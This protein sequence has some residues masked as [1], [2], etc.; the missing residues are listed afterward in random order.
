MELD[1]YAPPAVL[2]V[3][4]YRGR[5]NTMEPVK[6]WARRIAG[7]GM[8]AAAYANED[9]IADVH[10]AIEELRSRTDRI[11]LLAMSGNVPVALSALR[12]MRCAALLYGCMLDLDERTASFG[13]ADPK[14][15]FDDIPRDVPLFL[16]RAGRDQFDG[17]NE[18]ID[19]FVAQSL[20]HDLPV[21]LMNHAGAAHAA[22]SEEVIRATLRFLRD[23]LSD[24][25][26]STSSSARS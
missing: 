7:A 23:H 18:S 25:D 20:A 24:A 1:W 12:G 15:R 10:R 9:P 3:G 11:A 26:E 13:F 21:T 19:R 8:I 2:I 16:V 4:G 5:I 22:E 6:A 14:T 17:I